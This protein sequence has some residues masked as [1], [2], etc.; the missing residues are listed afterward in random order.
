MRPTPGITKER[1]SNSCREIFE[2]WKRTWTRCDGKWTGKWVIWSVNWIKRRNRV[3]PYRSNWNAYK[4]WFRSS[5]PVNNRC[6]QKKRLFFGSK[7]H[8]DRIHGDG[9]DR[10]QIKRV[11]QQMHSERILSS[12]FTVRWESNW[13]KSIEIHLNKLH[14]QW[15][16]TISRSLE[17]RDSLDKPRSIGFHSFIEFTLLDQK[18][19]TRKVSIEES[20][21]QWSARRISSVDGY[22]SFDEWH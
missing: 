5:R 19:R 7:I 18:A 10:L 16:T 13:K 17:E 15:D 22:C 8:R 1:R 11:D 3:P 12:T 6:L 21:M 14:F 20:H 4:N 2:D 9:R